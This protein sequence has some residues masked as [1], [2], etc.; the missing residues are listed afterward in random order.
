MLAS[1]VRCRQGLPAC[2]CPRSDPPAAGDSPLR[3]RRP[4]SRHKA[5][6][7][8]WH[9]GGELTALGGEL[10]PLGGELTLLGG[11]LTPLGGELTPLG[12]ELTPLGGELTPLGGE[13]AACLVRLAGMLFRDESTAEEVVQDSP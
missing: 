2:H 1:A 11:E 6:R 10:T 3:S 8:A 12:G 7:Q 13:L 9:R 5:G 4:G